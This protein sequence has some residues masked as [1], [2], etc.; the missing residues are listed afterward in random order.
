MQPEPAKRP[1]TVTEDSIG[2]LRTPMP[3]PEI[4]GPYFA[5]PMNSAK[6]VVKKAGNTCV[7]IEVM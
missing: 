2:A 1:V 6:V 3:E 4:A 7:A 5:V